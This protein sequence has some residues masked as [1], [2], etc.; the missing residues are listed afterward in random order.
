MDNEIRT[1]V[2]RTG[3]AEA[4][5]RM[6]FRALNGIEQMQPAEIVEWEYK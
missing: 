1:F 3:S 2:Y 4:L 5:T 6:A